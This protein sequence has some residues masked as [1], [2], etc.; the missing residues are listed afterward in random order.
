MKTPHEVV[1]D[2]VT[3]YNRRDAHAAA[4]LYHEDATNF[5]VALGD[6]TVGKRA[7]LEDL[8]SFFHAFP[9]NFTRV[10]NLFEDGEWAILEWFGA[11]PGGA[12]SPGWLRTAGRSRCVAAAF[13]TLPAAGS[14]S[15]ADISTRPPGLVNSVSH[16][17]EEAS[18]MRE[19]GI[20]SAVDHVEL[21]VPD[22]HEAAEWY[23]KALGLKVVRD[24][25][26][27]A[28]EGGPLMISGDGGNT[29]LALF[30]GE[31]RGSVTGS[32]T[33]GHHLTVRRILRRSHRISTPRSTFR[34]MPFHPAPHYHQGKL[35]ERRRDAGRK[36]AGGEGE[37]KPK[38]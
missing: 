10:E 9:D 38:R 12:S 20:G 22:R 16:S 15:S 2:W 30:E 7:I 23:E 27:W 34:S 14:G 13:S 6:L 18:E 37:Q 21:F 17:P 4:E 5:Q 31:A 33:S 3:A 24:L 35:N 29:M 32:E 8:L 26:E 28:T 36:P 25:E 11:A 19:P 1:Q